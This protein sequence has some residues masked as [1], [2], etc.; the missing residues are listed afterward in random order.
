MHSTPFSFVYKVKVYSR[1]N[2]NLAN[3]LVT[4]NNGT[5][6]TTGASISQSSS[7]NS[8]SEFFTGIEEK[9]KRKKEKD[10]PKEN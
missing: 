4:G 7:F 2:F 3:A 9:R 6:Q 5:N 8:L 1:S 10:P